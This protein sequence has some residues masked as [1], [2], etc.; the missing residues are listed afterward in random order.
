MRIVGM[1]SGVMRRSI[2][3]LG[4]IGMTA[5]TVHGAELVVISTT[6]CKE[7]LIELVPEYEKQS[8]NKINM[9][10]GGGS[11]LS[12]QIRAGG[13]RADIFIGPEE[14]SSPLIAEGKLVGSSRTAIVRSTTGLAVRAGA[15]KP[16][17]GSAE[18]LKSALLAARAVSYSAGASG[19]QFVKVLEK[20]GIADAVAAKKVA[21]KP[22][23]LVGAVVARG[24]ADIGVQQISELLP[25]SGIEIIGRLPSELETPIIYAAT[26]F[27]DS[28]QGAAAKSFVD[29]L[30]KS[31]TAHAVFKHKG[32][33]PLGAR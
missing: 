8:G 13:I 24:E 4:V 30:L 5:G 23:E 7:A 28:A 29:F 21:P 14:F 2:S 32:L 1:L 11:A 20:L 3:I 19:M 17:I 15:A 6:S 9:T 10:Y 26:A 12:Q 16:D 25:V 33:E 31:P 18:K 22:G 27:P